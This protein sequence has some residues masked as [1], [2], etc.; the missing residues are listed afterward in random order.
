MEFHNACMIIPWCSHGIMVLPWRSHDALM[1]LPWCSHG[2][3]WYFHIA[4][5]VRSWKRGDSMAFPWCFHG[6]PVARFP[7]KLGASMVLHGASW[8]FM[9]LS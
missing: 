2:L 8:C 6:N 7:W 9:V 3:S 5:M 4:L 1:M